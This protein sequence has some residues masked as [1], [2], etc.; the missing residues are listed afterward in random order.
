MLA[1]KC[2]RQSICHLAKNDHQYD[3]TI[4]PSVLEQYGFDINDQNIENELLGLSDID[5]YFN[6]RRIVTKIQNHPE[7]LI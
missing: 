7:D 5:I 6:Q 1:A 2:K 3:L 4:F